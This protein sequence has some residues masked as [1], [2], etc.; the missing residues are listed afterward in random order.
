MTNNRKDSTTAIRAVCAIVFILF[1]FLYIYFYQTPTLTYEQHVLSGGVTVYRPL[2]SAIII[3]AVGWMGQMFISG[4]CGFAKGFYALTFFPS[5]ALLAFL[6][7]G[8]SDGNGG[9]T[10]GN[11]IWMIGISLIIYLACMTALQKLH[12][13]AFSKDSLLFSRQLTLN[14]CIMVLMM[15]FVVK[16]S[17]G[18]SLLHRQVIA[19]KQLVNQDYGSLANE[20]KNWHGDVFMDTNPTLTLLRYIALDKRGELAEKLFAQPVV[21]STASLCRLEGI[22]P[23]ICK[24]KMLSRYKG[25]DYHLCAFLCDRDL[26]AFA[27]LLSDS[28]DIT[29]TGICDSLPVHYREALV[30]YQHQRSNPVAVYND[31]IMEADYDDLQQLVRSCKTENSRLD[32]LRRN[33]QATYWNYYYT[34]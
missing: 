24:K 31:S 6:T 21:G 5:M 28:I 33:Y 14:L 11:S 7:C 3:T 25:F 30:L 32:N 27:R 1:S 8:E 12:F 26:D 22:T 13:F 19:E 29:R 4:V 34:K 15:L 17:N 2:I 23:A 18:D 16:N 10:V 20:G 9:L